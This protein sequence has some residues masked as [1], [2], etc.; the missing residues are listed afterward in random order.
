[1]G[2]FDILEKAYSKFEEYSPQVMDAMMKEME[3]IEKKREKTERKIDEKKETYE[4]F[5]LRQL[6]KKLSLLKPK[7]DPN[8]SL[9]K[10]AI[11]RI[12]RERECQINHYMSEYSG[13]PSSILKL[14]RT[15]VINGR[16]NY[17]NES[18]RCQELTEVEA[19]IRLIA[20]DKILSERKNGEY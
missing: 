17:G 2:L 9:K 11:S 10:T 12:V 18:F 5:T 3:N 14:E 8:Y 6:N 1:M 4:G 7:N 13:L 16:A 19:E 15:N 20:I